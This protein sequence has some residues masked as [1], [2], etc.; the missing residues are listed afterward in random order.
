MRVQRLLALA[1]TVT[2]VFLIISFL[3][4]IL[5][6]L[7]VTFISLLIAL[8][9]TSIFIGFLKL[10]LLPIMLTKRKKETEP[11]PSYFPLER[12]QEPDRK[13]EE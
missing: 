6:F 11:K 9:L 2:M 13:E 8:T 10:I 4:Q 7:G 5:F 3:W 12:I 1:L